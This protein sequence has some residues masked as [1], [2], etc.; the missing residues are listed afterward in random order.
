MG[1][2]GKEVYGERM[3]EWVEEIVR[4]VGLVVEWMEKVVREVGLM[5]MKNRYEVLVVGMI[6]G[7]M[8]V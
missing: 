8:N 3:V 7:D 2:K 5:G 1:K 6:D 4:E